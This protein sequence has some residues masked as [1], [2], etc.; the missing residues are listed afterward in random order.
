M[1]TGRLDISIAMS[2]G[3]F[4]V[5]DEAEWSPRVSAPSGFLHQRY[6][7]ETIEKT[8]CVVQIFAA[9]PPP[10]TRSCSCRG[11][12]EVVHVIPVHHGRRNDSIILV[13]VT[14]SLYVIV[15][16]LHRVEDWDSIMVAT[17]KLS[18]PFSSP[19][20]CP[21]SGADS[22]Q[23]QPVPTFTARGRY[24]NFQEQQEQQGRDEDGNGGPLSP[25]TNTMTPKEETYQD[26][27]RTDL[28]GGLSLLLAC[29]AQA[30]PGSGCKSKPPWA[31]TGSRLPFVG[32]PRNPPE[33]I[34]DR[35]VFWM[36][37]NALST[38]YGIV[39]PRPCARAP[40]HKGLVK[41]DMGMERGLSSR[42]SLLTASPLPVFVHHSEPN[43]DHTSYIEP[44]I[45]PLEPRARSLP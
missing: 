26:G 37:P 21:V 18:K 7:G 11:I 2:I 3:V 45:A 25:F 16:A 35:A 8:W 17:F 19:R 34:A 24:I 13:A 38:C 12:D 41:L 32:S 4:L 42:H 10:P 6:F 27:W 5:G 30:L 15:G 20:Q 1:T 23:V 29:P 44:I 33:I 40:A 9:S 14:K 43:R 39:H 31:M 28:S 36:K 22:T